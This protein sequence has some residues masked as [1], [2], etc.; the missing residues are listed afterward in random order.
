MKTKLF[1]FVSVLFISTSVF[2]QIPFSHNAPNANGAERI[3]NFGVTGINDQRIEI[4]NAT[5]NN[6]EFLPALWTHNG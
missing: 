4:T 3:S 2:T 5:V 1:F 6:G